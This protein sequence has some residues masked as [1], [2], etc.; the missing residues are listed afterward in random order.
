MVG[1]IITACVMF[2]LGVMFGTY[3]CTQMWIRRIKKAAVR[4]L[5]EPGHWY[6]PGE[7]EM[8]SGRLQ[9]ANEL[10]DV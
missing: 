4:R 7:V 10:M 9:L 6:Q 3:F 5:F 1:L 8:Y 2:S